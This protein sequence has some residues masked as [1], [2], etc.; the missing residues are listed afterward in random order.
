MYSIDYRFKAVIAK[1]GVL[2]RKAAAR[3]AASMASSER[4]TWPD[5]DPEGHLSLHFTQ[6]IRNWLPL[7]PANVGRSFAH[8]SRRRL[9]RGDAGNDRTVPRRE[10]VA[11]FGEIGC[12]T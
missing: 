4:A 7:M 10:H 1:L 11:N 8:R 3:L 9:A 12:S 6:A 2:N 5:I